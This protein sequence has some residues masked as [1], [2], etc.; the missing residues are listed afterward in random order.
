MPCA[1]LNIQA[2]SFQLFQFFH[3]PQI[4]GSHVV[5]NPETGNANHVVPYR[6]ASGYETSCLRFGKLQADQ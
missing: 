3:D 6:L 5:T 4:P 2:I 1:E